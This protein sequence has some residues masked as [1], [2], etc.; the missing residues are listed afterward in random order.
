MEA[1]AKADRNGKRRENGKN[2]HNWPL[3]ALLTL[4][5]RAS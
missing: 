1:T 3:Y 5:A 2:T 4:E